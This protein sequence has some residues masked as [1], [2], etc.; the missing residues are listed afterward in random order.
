MCVQCVGPG[1]CKWWGAVPADSRNRHST[2]KTQNLETSGVGVLRVLWTWGL[3]QD[4]NLYL[5]LVNTSS[6]S[7]H[8]PLKEQQMVPG[9]HLGC[10]DF[11]FFLREFTVFIISLVELWHLSPGALHLKSS[12]EKASVSLKNWNTGNQQGTSGVK[13]WWQMVTLLETSVLGMQP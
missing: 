11:F 10:M 7:A 3:T 8:K 5:H 9:Y 2:L 13:A 6:E 12:P 1:T 4:G